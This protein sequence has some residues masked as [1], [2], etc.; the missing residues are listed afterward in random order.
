MFNVLGG[1]ID[2]FCNVLNIKHVTIKDFISNGLN[3]AVVMFFTI[4]SGSRAP[5]SKG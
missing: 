5:G 4:S 3:I 2:L 1:R